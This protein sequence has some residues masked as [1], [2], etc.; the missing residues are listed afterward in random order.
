MAQIR[1]IGRSVIESKLGKKDP[2]PC[3]S[4]KKYKRCCLEKDEAAGK[5]QLR[6]PQAARAPNAPALPQTR[7]PITPQEELTPEEKWWEDFAERCEEAKSGADALELLRV[8]SSEGPPLDEDLLLD[9]LGLP[10]KRVANDGMHAECMAVIDALSARFPVG[11]GQKSSYFER[12]RFESAL[13]RAD[14]NIVGV[15][16]GG[17]SRGEVRAA[18]ESD[19]HGRVAPSC[20]E[21][22]VARSR[23]AVCT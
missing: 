12:W 14:V 7:T 13:E 20:G 16:Q 4:G 18:P 19:S 17:R 6:P 9:Y 22:L 8:A 1:A 11:A 10:I 15:P 21:R 2:C 5:S 23:L 3:G